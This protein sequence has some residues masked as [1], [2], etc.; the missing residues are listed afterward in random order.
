[1][2]LLKYV[3]N[4]KESNN[5]KFFT[6]FYASSNYRLVRLRKINKDVPAQIEELDNIKNLWDSNNYDEDNILLKFLPNS[7]QII[8]CLTMLKK[9][10]L[11]MLG[12]Q[13]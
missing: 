11:K 5:A 6:Y 1:M 10:V 4:F 2:V 8:L 3:E 9:G 12:I 7:F 13:R